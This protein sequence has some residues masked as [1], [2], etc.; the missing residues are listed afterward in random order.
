MALI[1]KDNQPGHKEYQGPSQHLLLQLSP[2]IYQR[3]LSARLYFHRTCCER[4]QE[5]CLYHLYRNQYQ[6]QEVILFQG[7]KIF[8]IL[9]QT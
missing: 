5:P 8:Q 4:I 3:L 7:L 6:S 2:A 9:I 1:C